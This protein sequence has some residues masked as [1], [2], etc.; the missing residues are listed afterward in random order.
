MQGTQVRS[1]IWDDSTCRAATEPVCHSYWASVLE[2]GRWNHWARVLQMPKLARSRACALHEAT[3]LQWE[4]HASQLESSPRWHQLQ[5]SPHKATAQ[6]KRHK[7]IKKNFFSNLGKI[8]NKIL[9]AVRLQVT[10]FF[11][12]VCSS[13]AIL[14]NTMC[15][16]CLLINRKKCLDSISETRS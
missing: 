11:F 2:P 14:E 16:Y 8:Y 12:P 1:L 15:M 13:V 9:A 4:A 3:P 6:P 7:N 10:Y 5:K